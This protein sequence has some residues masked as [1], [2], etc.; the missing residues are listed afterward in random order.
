M[1]TGSWTDEEKQIVRNTYLGDYISVKNIAGILNRTPSSVANMVSTLG[2]R[3]YSRV[4]WNDCEERQ[5]EA[6]VGKFS[7][8]T[9]ARRLHRS[10]N[11]VQLKVNRMKL[12]SRGYRE[13]WYNQKDISDIFGVSYRWVAARL[14]DGTIKA[15]RYGSEI[16]QWCVREEDLKE[17][18]KIRSYEL[19]GLRVDIQQ[20][21]WI[22][23][24][25]K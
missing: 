7:K 6:W 5:L 25:V 2:L 21:V 11:A 24:A 13:G 4:K 15:E 17:Y 19:N 1:V 10:I 14:K 23:T 3:R 20:I 18:I 22:L 12:G 9:I 16:G 8:S